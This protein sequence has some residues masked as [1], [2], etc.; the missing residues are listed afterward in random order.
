MYKKHSRIDQHHNNKQQR[1]VRKTTSSQNSPM[2]KYSLT[3]RRYSHQSKFFHT[4]Q[5]TTL[6]LNKIE[7]ANSTTKLE[8]RVN[9]SFRPLAASTPYGIEQSNPFNDGSPHSIM[10]NQRLLLTPPIYCSTP[11]QMRRQ[12]PN[13][14]NSHGR[15]TS[16]FKQKYNLDQHPSIPI[17]SQRRLQFTPNSQSLVRY[18]ND[19]TRRINI[20]NIK[21]WLL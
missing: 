1:I 3:K 16:S 20:K 11:K 18:S 19:D 8:N 4:Q 14:N 13:N 10:R 5:E 15:S 12:I 2:G 6:I 21:I 7:H 9:T 17:I